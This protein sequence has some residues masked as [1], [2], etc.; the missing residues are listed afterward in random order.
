METTD[1]PPGDAPTRAGWAEKA[2]LQLAPVTEIDALVG[3]RIRSRRE[4]LGMSQGRLGRSLGVTFSQVQ[5]YEKG[6]N[7]IGA[8]RLYHVAALLG[9]P[10]QYFFEGVDEPAPAQDAGD[11]ASAADAER[12]RDAFARISDPHARQAL[13]SLAATMVDASPPK[14]GG[15]ATRSLGSPFETRHRA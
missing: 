9:V 10:V 11:Q 8:G 13:L 3:S 12:L 5:K 4:A 1:M 2:R 7:R 15:A 6:S 14:P